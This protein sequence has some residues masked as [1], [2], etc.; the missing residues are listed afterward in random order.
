MTKQGKQLIVILIAAIAALYFLFPAPSTKKQKM[1]V[2]D[3]ALMEFAD[4]NPPPRRLPP[5]AGRPAPGINVP[6]PQAAGFA[7]MADRYGRSD[8]FAPFYDVKEFRE[9]P[10]ELPDLDPLPPMLLKNPANMK[11]TAIVFKKGVGMAIINSEVLYKGDA[12]QGFQVKELTVDK[13]VLVND[14][15]DKIVLQLKQEGMEGF[16]SF[17][18]GLSNIQ[19]LPVLPGNEANSSLIPSIGIGAPSIPAPKVPQPSLTVKATT[20]QGAD[21]RSKEIKAIID[22]N[23][24]IDANELL[25]TKENKPR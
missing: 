18:D 22:D 23:T 17:G 13:V 19:E 24:L 3:S 25:S 11:L 6:P 20:K 15:D 10:M 12:I 1:T 8:P 9:Q 7:L 4:D 21:K 5:Q 16:G 2:S 14:M